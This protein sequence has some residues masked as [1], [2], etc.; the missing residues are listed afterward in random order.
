MKFNEHWKLNGKH[1]MFSPSQNSWLKYSD[2][3]AAEIYESKKAAERGT[4][5]HAW[6]KD[7]ID[8]GIKMGKS[9][10]TLNMYVNDAIGFAMKTEVVLYYSDRFF[11]T[12]DTIS[13]RDDVLRIHD[14]KTGKH[15]VTMDQL[16]VYAALFCLEYHIKP[17][18]ILV[19]L[20]IYQNDEITIA[21]PSHDR[22][23]EIMKKIV[24]LDALMAALDSDEE[25]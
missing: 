24:H 25:D 9:K 3:R 14:L 4:R 5:L 19:E 23:E 16:E 13:F 22:I 10:K 1:A 6:A 7:T 18:N 11:G 15:P 17:K 21:N 20:R 2:E 8:L 12:A